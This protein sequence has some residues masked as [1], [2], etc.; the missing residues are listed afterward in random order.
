MNSY[1]TLGGLPEELLSDI[2]ALFLR[3][4][5]KQ[6]FIYWSSRNV[7]AHA[8]MLLVRL[9]RLCLVCRKFNRIA[10]QSYFEPNRLFV[11]ISVTKAYS[12]PH[13]VREERP[14]Q[15]IR[16][17]SLIERGRWIVS[18]LA[19]AIRGTSNLHPVFLD[20]SQRL[21]I[22]VPNPYSELALD[23]LIGKI[24][25]ILVT[26]K[27]LKD[28]RVEQQCMWK[29]YIPNPYL[30]QKLPSNCSRSRNIAQ[31]HVRGSM[32]CPALRIC[33]QLFCRLTGIDIPGPPDF[34][35]N[36]NVESQ[37]HGK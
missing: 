9:H 22:L 17:D 14:W 5:Y 7:M 8:R 33:C 12:S 6:E 3:P 19:R 4:K 26:S 32:T 11:M 1:P 24:R 30:F 10:R 34:E 36:P 23:Q 28:V 27:K 16:E 20:N 37:K 13:I 2:L 31:F 35:D 25:Q 29:D 21:S 18:P 15:T